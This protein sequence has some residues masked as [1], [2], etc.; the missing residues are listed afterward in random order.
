MAS[1]ESIDEN[2]ALELEDTAVCPICGRPTSGEPCVVCRASLPESPPPR[3]EDTSSG[4]E[5][6]YRTSGIADPDFDPMTLIAS[7]DDV[8]EE[9]L[10]AAMG[11]LDSERGAALALLL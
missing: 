3:R 11:S 1:A 5:L 8:R 7:A 9:L 4:Y 10:E 2:P 6:Q